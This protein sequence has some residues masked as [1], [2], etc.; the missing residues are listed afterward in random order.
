LYKDVSLLSGRI[1]R[2]G[3][4][5]CSSAFYLHYAKRNTRHPHSTA[6]DKYL[7]ALEPEHHQLLVPSSDIGCHAADE[8]IAVAQPVTMSS[9]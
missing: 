3:A 1:T 4:L 2:L 7:L 8:S 5:I 9:L 6:Q